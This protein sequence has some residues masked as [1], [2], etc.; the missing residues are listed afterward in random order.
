MAAL[1]ER[2]VDVRSAWVF[3]ID[4]FPDVVEP[5]LNSSVTPRTKASRRSGL[6]CQEDKEAMQ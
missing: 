2:V 4:K 3:I 6:A 5:G 1:A